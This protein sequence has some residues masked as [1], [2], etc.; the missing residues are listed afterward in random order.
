MR[1]L[2]MLAVVAGALC[3]AGSA[4]KAEAGSV[5]IG[6]GPRVGYG[7]GY[8]G[9]RGYGNGGYRGYGWGGGYGGYGGLLNL[10]EDLKYAFGNPVFANVGKPAP[11]EV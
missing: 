6:V 2:L 10:A 5:Y 3:F 7:Y 11:W 4:T 9:Y 8:G 1:K